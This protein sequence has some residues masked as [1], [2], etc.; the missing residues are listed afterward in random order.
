MSWAG[1]PGGGRVHFSNRNF[2]RAFLT[3]HADLRDDTTTSRVQY[4]RVNPA[5]VR[6]ARGGVGVLSKSR[7][8]APKPADQRPPTPA[9]GWSR[10]TS[11]RAWGARPH[12]EDGSH[13]TYIGYVRRRGVGRRSVFVCRGMRRCITRRVVFASSTSSWR[14]ACVRHHDPPGRLTARKWLP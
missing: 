12:F 3:R 2:A 5:P 6:L 8:E 11:S 1:R 14:E 7:G 13:Y 9:P 10:H 4:M